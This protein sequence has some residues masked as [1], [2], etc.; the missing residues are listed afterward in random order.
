MNNQQLKA[1]FPKLLPP[2]VV[3]WWDNGGDIRIQGYLVRPKVGLLEQVKDTELLSL[4]WEVEETFTDAEIGR[5]YLLISQK[6]LNLK[7]AIMFNRIHASW[8]QRIQSA[9]EVRGIV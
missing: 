6:T 1:L 2:T 8:Q 3:Y 9:G 7:K 5:Y 4:C